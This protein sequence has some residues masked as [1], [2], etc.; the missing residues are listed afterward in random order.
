MGWI[1]GGL[2]AALVG[3]AMQSYGQAE[4]NRKAQ[5]KMKAAQYPGECSG[6]DQCPDSGSGGRL[7]VPETYCQSG[8]RGQPHCFRH[9]GGCL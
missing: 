8:G 5:A 6:Q 7:R 4:A 3:T 9:Q 2:I 1:I